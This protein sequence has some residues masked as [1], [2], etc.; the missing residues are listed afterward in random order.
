M[1]ILKLLGF[2]SAFGND[3]VKK[4]D[5]I[6]DRLSVLVA[7][8]RNTVRDAAANDDNRDQSSIPIQRSN[9]IA[10]ERDD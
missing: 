1:P 2:Y 9:R 5:L 7:R 10:M 3:V 8:G 4:K 6:A